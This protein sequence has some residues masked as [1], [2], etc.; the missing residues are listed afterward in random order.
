MAELAATAFAALAS[1]ST[2][3]AGWAAGTT[4][5]TAAGA[6]SSLLGSSALGALSTGLT[7][8]SS[9]S[10]LLGGYMSYRQA[11]MQA[12]VAGLNAESARIESEEKAIRIRRELVQKTGAARV[13]FAGAGLDISSG[14]AIEQGYRSEA[15]A[16]IRFARSGGEIAAAG[17]EMAGAQYRTR[18]YASLIEAAGRAAIGGGQ[19]A[20]SIARR[21]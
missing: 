1:S 11:N 17:Q 7:V 9:V 2:A 20:L 3:A 14:S 4:I 16:E 8:A 5:T 12:D 19:Q 10:A 13:A 21:G 6:T 18:G 15:D